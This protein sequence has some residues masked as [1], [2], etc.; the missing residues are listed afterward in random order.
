ML[1]TS[2]QY[3]LIPLSVLPQILPFDFGNTPINSGDMAS[4]TCSINK[5]DLPLNITWTFNNRAINDVDGVAVSFVNKRL[6]ALS[7]ESVQAEHAGQYT[8][9]ATNAAGRTSYSTNLNV[10]GTALFY[11]SL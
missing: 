4:T 2:S 10:N 3:P 6:S 9:I 7:I 1:L 5:G 11:I 8:C